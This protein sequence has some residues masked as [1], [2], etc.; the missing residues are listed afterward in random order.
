MA[1]KDLALLEDC[2]FL[3]KPYPPTRLAEVVRASLDRPV[4]KTL[5]RVG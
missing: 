2:N 1:G 3:P 5:S 4:N